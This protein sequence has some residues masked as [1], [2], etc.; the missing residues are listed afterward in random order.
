MMVQR[1]IWPRESSPPQPCNLHW[2]YLLFRWLRCKA[3]SW[4]QLLQGPLLSGDGKHRLRGGQKYVFLPAFGARG[5]YSLLWFVWIWE[6]D[7]FL[8]RMLPGLKW[9]SR[10]IWCY[11]CEEN[12]SQFVD[13][14][15]RTKGWWGCVTICGSAA[16][17][18]VVH[19]GRS[20]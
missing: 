20:K 18:R 13:T 14:N 1:L 3:L 10:W 4:N 8:N 2:W 17:K 15:G 19:R 11:G 12:Q 7:F 6:D 5:H 16:E 9:A